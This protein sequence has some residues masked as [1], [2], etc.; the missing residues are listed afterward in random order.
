M[1]ERRPGC[2]KRESL[3]KSDAQR[4][5]EIIESLFA[6][7]VRM[8]V[9]AVVIKLKHSKGGVFAGNQ[10]QAAA[11]LTG[12]PPRVLGRITGQASATE[13]RVN[14]R[15]REAAALGETRAG[16][17]RPQVPARASEDRKSTRL[18]S[19]HQ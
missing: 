12:P 2:R 13:H 16:A 11:H 4:Q 3:E 7:I 10:I 14:E 6:D 19:S 1:R 18:N 15:L 5:R 17:K 8:P 9:I